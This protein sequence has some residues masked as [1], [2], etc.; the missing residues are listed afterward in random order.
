PRG[1]IDRVTGGQ[2][3]L[4]A[5]HHLAGGN[6]DPSLH[7][8]LGKGVAHLHRGPNSPESVV[9]V[10]DWHAEDSHH[11]VADELLDRAA[12]ALDDRLHRLEVGSE[13]SPQRLRV[14]LLAQLSRAGD[15]AEE[16]RYDLALFPSWGGLDERRAAHAAEPEAFGVLLAALRADEHPSSVR[17]SC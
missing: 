14:E 10:H 16:N 15:V 9:L 6:T 12:V 5:C 1:D 17:P 2:A 11:C 8:Q 13:Q 7:T 4:R 3:L